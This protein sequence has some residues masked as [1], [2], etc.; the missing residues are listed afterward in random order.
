M[1]LHFAIFPKPKAA[2][3]KAH[4]PNLI[5]LPRT[6]DGEVKGFIPC[7]FMPCNYETD[8]IMLYFHGNSEDLGGVE[9]FFIPLKDAWKVHVLAVEYPSYGLYSDGPALSED[10]IKEDAEMVY[11]CLQTQ[12]AL[13]EDQIIIF[14]RSMGT[15]PAIHLASKYHP[16]MLYL[17]SPFKSIREAAGNLT[18]GW[19]ASLVKERFR[20]IDH[21]DKVKCPVLT[22]HGKSDKLVPVSHSEELMDKC[23]SD[24]KKLETPKDM[25]HGEYDL[26]A[27]LIYPLDKF[28]DEHKLS[29][30]P[31]SKVDIDLFY[32][33]KY[34][35]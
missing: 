27:D 13:K 2:T 22:V 8:K 4:H 5:W 32:A 31:N 33:F 35:N 20:N 15:G 23:T 3:Y 24:K 11:N 12:C 34:K 28:M 16:L 7:L 9:Q 30:S 10:S 29:P 25:S 14:G 26:F 6:M 1:D 18:F 17:F 19:L 21:I